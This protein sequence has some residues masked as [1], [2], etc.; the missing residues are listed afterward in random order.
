MM[1][2]N[3]VKGVEIGD[4]FAAARLRGEDNADPMQ[5]GNDGKPVFLANHAGGVAGGIATGQP[6]VVRIALKPTSSIL[7]PVETITRDGDPSEI[8]TKGRHDPCV[9][10]SA[11]PVAE[12]SEERRDGKGCG[13]TCRS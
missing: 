12:R 3:A 6:V 9:G 7:T 1:S 13:G 2:I 5:P 11:A 4:G 10:I 8:K